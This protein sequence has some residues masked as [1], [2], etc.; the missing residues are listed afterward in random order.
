MP[1]DMSSSGI[2][3]AVRSLQFVR[4]YRRSLV[5]V[6]VLALILATLSAI[7]PLLMKYLFDQLGRAGGGHAFGLAMAGLLVMELVRSGLQACLGVRSWDVR[8]GVEY[9]VREQVVSKLNSLPISF[10][11]KE[12]VGGTVNRIN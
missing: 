11:Q 8:L 3:L 5:S 6:V 10:H 1:D 7:D 4:P 2:Q 12:G 9:R